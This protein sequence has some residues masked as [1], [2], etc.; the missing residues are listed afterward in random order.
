MSST[1]SVFSMPCN[2]GELQTAKVLHALCYA[3]LI[4]LAAPYLHEMRAGQH[5]SMGVERVSPFHTLIP[6]FLHVYDCTQPFALP[7]NLPSLYVDL[8]SIFGSDGASISEVR[9]PR[10]TRGRGGEKGEEGWVRV[11]SHPL[12]LS[13]AHTGPRTHIFLLLMEPGFW[14][15]ACRW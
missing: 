12:P 10:R 7:L 5:R 11:A 4:L 2:L 9:Q 3:D 6:P 8:A 15:C 14:C 13:Q 1:R